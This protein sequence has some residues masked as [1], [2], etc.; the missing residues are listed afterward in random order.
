MIWLRAFLQAISMYTVLPLPGL[1]WESRADRHMLALFPLTGLLVGGAWYGLA[2]L[3]LGWGAP[4][5]VTGA[6]LALL[7]FL[8][9]GFLH[10]DGYMDVSDA[11]LS[12]RDKERRLE[13]LRDPHCGAFAVL[14]AAGLFLVQFAAAGS[15]PLCPERLPCLLILPVLA[16]GLCGFLLLALPTLSG[17]SMAAWLKQDTGRLDRALPIV[18]ASLAA[19]GMA[20]FGGL[21]GAAAALAALLG[22][23]L[24]AWFAFRQLGGMSGDTT[25]YS[26]V[27]TELMGLLVLVCI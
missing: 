2:L 15:L 23:G 16:R 24:A 26:L 13:I 4:A 22:G 17:S 9:T 27:W 20:V 19:V 25:G 1:R 6:L 8:A 3:L 5:L 14:A 18:L 7:P 12:R 10:L 21:A 11:V